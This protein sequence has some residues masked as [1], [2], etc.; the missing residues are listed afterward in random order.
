VL[1]SV[2]NLES[3]EMKTTL[4][5]VLLWLMASLAMAILALPA[6]ADTGRRK[7]IISQ[8]AY[9]PGGTNMQSILMLLQAPD[10]EVLGIVVG[11]GDGWRD[12]NIQHTLRLLEIAGRP[13][14]PVYAGTVLPLLNSAEKTQRWESMYGELSYKGAWSKPI[15]KK[16]H[17]DPYAVPALPEGMA[18][19]KPAA[20][21]G[22]D[23]MIRKVHEFPGQVTIWAAGPLT[24]LAVAA[25]LDS[26]FS[27]LAKELVFMGGSFRPVPAANAFADEYRHNTRLEFNLR[28]DPEAASIVLHEPW[29]QVLQI[30][31][32]PTTATFFRPE[33]LARIANGKTPFASYIGQYGQPLPMWDELAAMVWIDPGIVKRSSTM[34]VDVDT[35]FTA[36]YGN[37]LSWA[38]GKGPH[39][40]ERPVLVI[41]EIDVPRFEQMTV[42][43]L[44]RPQTVNG[45]RAHAQ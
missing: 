27:S 7:L 18:T 16:R 43:L 44:T 12:E 31:V 37:T 39:L 20:E 3:S 45:E 40:G 8:D 29:K 1:A 25:R 38:L 5:R 14:V 17:A 33:L 11:S 41:Q 36:G 6:N 19:I 42:D 4:D 21:S 30:P 24:D 15:D 35:S 28:W 26:A 2:I 10:V 9:G 13:E 34:L 22:A 32:D 23:F